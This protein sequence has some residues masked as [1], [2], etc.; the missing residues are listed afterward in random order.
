MTTTRLATAALVLALAPVLPGCLTCTE[1]GCGAQLYLSASLA[2]D[3]DVVVEVCRAGTCFDAVSLTR[4]GAVVNIQ[5]TATLQIDAYRTTAREL[6]ITAT[7][8]S[9]TG[10]AAAPPGEVE[11]TVRVTGASSGAIID[12]TFVP[13]YEREFPNGEACGPLCY[14]HV[15]TL[16]TLSP[17][18]P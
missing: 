18:A 12:S 17:S 2:S 9:T 8:R 7:E 15:S 16:E 3:E 6:T 14:Q 1:I 11:W 13:A 4:P 5:R 10:A